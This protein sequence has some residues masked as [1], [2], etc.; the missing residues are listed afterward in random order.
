MPA[1]QAATSVASR[2]SGGTLDAVRVSSHQC[3]SWSLADIPRCP[4]HVRYYPVISTD[5]RNTF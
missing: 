1:S 3:R 5:R 4:G 2:N